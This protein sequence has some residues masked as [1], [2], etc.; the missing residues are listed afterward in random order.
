MKTDIQ[1]VQQ[2]LD[3]DYSAFD[4][5][6]NR[7]QNAIY[8]FILNTIRDTEAAKDICQEVFINAYYKLY[9]YKQ[10]YKF[11][12]WL[13][14]IAMNKSIDYIRK[15]KKVQNVPL[16]DFEMDYMGSSPEYLAEYR[17]TK[18]EIEDFIKTLRE[19]DRQILMIKYSNE[20]I[21]FREI[22]EILKLSESTVKYKYYNIYDR[23]EKY[24]SKRKGVQS[25]CEL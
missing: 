17:E 10:K 15:N 13:F 18:R 22:A 12:S 7:Y 14:Q 23:Y 20:N 24:I 1:V 21:T 9:T 3:G 6:L 5:I 4:E 8:R 2:V 25:C 19:V 16:S 11:S